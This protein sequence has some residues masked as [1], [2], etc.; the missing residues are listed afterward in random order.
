[1]IGRREFITLLGCAGAWPLAARAQQGER[2]RRIGVLMSQ[3]ADDPEGQP[4]LLAL[5]QALQESGW[6]LGRNLQ[7]ETRW[8]A[9][10]ADRYRRYAAELVGLAPDVMLVNGPAALLHLQQATR[11][12]PIVFTS[13]IDPVGGGFIA[14]LARPGG[15]VTGFMP[16][17]FSLSGKLL[18]LLKEIVPVRGEAAAGDVITTSPS[19]SSAAAL[20]AL[21]WH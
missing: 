15:N 2:V 20:A 18:E 10:D 17:E 12:V 14:N 9:G 5:A 21:R 19:T 4:R 11:G 6:T 1:M 3:A 8:G 7:I 16:Y 13:V